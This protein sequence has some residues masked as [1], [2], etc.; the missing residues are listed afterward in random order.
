[1]NHTC[2]LKFPSGI[3]NT[4]VNEDGK[5]KMDSLTSSRYRCGKCQND[6][7]IDCDVFVHE[8]LHNCPGCENK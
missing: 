3:K 7:C 5:T 8:S 1:M 6:F 2:L 4:D